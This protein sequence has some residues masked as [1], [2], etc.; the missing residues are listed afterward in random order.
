MEIG[1]GEGKGAQLSYKAIDAFSKLV[2]L[3]VK[4]AE[5]RAKTS[6]LSKVLEVVSGVLR[7]EL[8]NRRARGME[9]SMDQRPYFR[10]LLNLQQDLTA[11]Y[12]KEGLSEENKLAM[13]ST[14]ADVY[15]RVLPPMHVPVFAF[16]WLELVSHRSFMPKLLKVKT[17][18]GWHVLQSLLVDLFTFLEPFLRDI[19]LSP[20]IRLLYK[21]TLR[22]LLVLLHDFPEFLCSFHFSLCDVIPPTCIQLRNLILS[23]KSFVNNKEQRLNLI[24]A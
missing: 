2:V 1:G 6:L 21:G 24:T 3:L 9:G 5:V 11:S 14:F 18:S 20:S 7:R 13:L 19:Q 12:E 8:E 17:E 4:Y 16:A 10:I 22:V 23:G 15:H